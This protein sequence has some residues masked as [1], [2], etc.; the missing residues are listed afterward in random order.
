MT[1]SDIL[2]FSL[3]VGLPAFTIAMIAI[4][5]VDEREKVERVRRRLRRDD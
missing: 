5:I 2:T 4:V 3:L 1:I